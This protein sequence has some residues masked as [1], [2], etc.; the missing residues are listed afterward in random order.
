[1]ATLKIAK[2]ELR[3][4]IRKT[5]SSLSPE[6][7]TSQSGNVFNTLTQLPEYKSAKRIGIY[8]SM[9]SGE[10]DT[11]PIVLDALQAGKTVFVPYTYNHTAQSGQ[12]VSLMDMLSLHSLTDYQ[13]LQPDNWGIP[14]PSKDSIAGRQNCLGDLGRLPADR[15][16]IEQGKGGLDFLVMPGMAFDTKLGRLGH[17]KGFYDM[18]LQK[19]N[20]N[21][22]SKLGEN[23]KM[24]LLIGLSLKEQL[25]PEEQEVPKDSTDWLLDGLIV[26]DGRVL[27]P[28]E[29]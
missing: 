17:G 15:V 1:M 2:R 4:Q 8:L 12:T 6:S 27:G 13:S 16:G 11:A 26:G 29:H 22:K 3:Q 9:P 10:I 19:M 23:A 5:L 7:V 24:P 20:E 21:Q 28:R 18:F 14:T 25:L